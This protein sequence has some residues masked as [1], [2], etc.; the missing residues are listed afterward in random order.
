M[1]FLFDIEYENHS[2]ILPIYGL[3]YLFRAILCHSERFQAV[4]DHL[5]LFQ[6]IPDCSIFDIFSFDI[7]YVNHQ[8]ILLIS[9]LL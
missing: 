5:R 8:V 1:Y 9:G 2:A 7:E 3:L 4:P 6:T